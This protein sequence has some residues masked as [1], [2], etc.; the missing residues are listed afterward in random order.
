MAEQELRPLAGESP[1]ALLGLFQGFM[2]SAAMK[3]G[4]DL[5]IFTH[6]AHGVDT[7]EKLAAAKHLTARAARIVGHALVAFGTLG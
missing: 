6:I 4:L 7:A 2:G 1:D 5:E 3:A